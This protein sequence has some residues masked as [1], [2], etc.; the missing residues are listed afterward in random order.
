MAYSRLR[1]KNSDRTGLA[2]H[3]IAESPKPISTVDGL[4][5]TKQLEPAQTAAMMVGRKW[6]G[7]GMLPTALHSESIIPSA[8]PPPDAQRP[9]PHLSLWRAE[10]TDAAI[11]QAYRRSVQSRM[12]GQLRTALWVWAALLML[13]AVPDY[14]VL[15][16]NAVFWTL[17]GLRTATTLLLLGAAQALRTRPHLAPQGHLAV[18]L[19]MAGYSFLFLFLALRP[20]T[21]ESSISTFMVVNLSL[22]VFIPGRVALGAWVAAAGIAGSIAALLFTGDTLAAIPSLALLLTLPA[23]VGFISANR[24]QRVQRREFIVRR[25]LQHANAALQEEIARG[26]AL[27][28]ELQSQANT[29]PLTGLLNRREFGRCFALDLA[30][31]ERDASALSIVLLDLD[32]FKAINDRYG[33][34]AGDEVLR[35][36]ARLCLECFR[37]IDSVGRMGGEE[38]AVLLPG[39]TLLEAAAV[40]QRFAQKLAASPVTHGGHHMALTATLGVAQRLAHETVLDDV[41]GR[42]DQAMYAGKTA[43]RNCVMLATAAGPPQRYAAECAHLPSPFFSSSPAQ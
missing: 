12:A 16:G 40:A 13:F 4:I 32:H 35:Q 27:Q 37:S 21:R 30:R 42:A 36:V 34:A 31:A 24:L 33:H 19:Q 3:H 29:D 2:R 15:G 26:N 22:F 28:A 23:V 20:E 6:H 11:E 9:P 38:I 17:V 1:S 43:S 8:H 14:Q 25:R 5:K 41:L 10:F 39:T 18:A 7:R